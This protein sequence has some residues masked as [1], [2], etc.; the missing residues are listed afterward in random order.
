MVFGTALGTPGASS[1]SEPNDF[2]SIT[3]DKGTI[4]P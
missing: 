4:Q 2:G 1:T 3:D